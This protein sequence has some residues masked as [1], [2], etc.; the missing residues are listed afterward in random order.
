MKNLQSLILTVT[1]LSGCTS[2]IASSAS[3]SAYKVDYDYSQG[4]SETVHFT[5]TDRSVFAVAKALLKGFP[6]IERKNAK[7]ILAFLNKESDVPIHLNVSSSE[8]QFML[9]LVQKPSFKDFSLQDFNNMRILADRIGLAQS[10]KNDIINAAPLHHACYL[11]YRNL[12]ENH[13]I[14]FY[15]T[16]VEVALLTISILFF[17]SYANS[18]NP[19]RHLR[20]FGQLGLQPTIVYSLIYFMILCSD[21]CR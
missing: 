2:L 11:K 20:N 12:R 6:G 18:E 5:T 3:K 17:I 15:A 9:K 1:V 16:G 4:E 7:H 14:F 8:L 21:G 10:H 19:N 13:P